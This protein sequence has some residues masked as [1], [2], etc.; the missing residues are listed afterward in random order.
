[1]IFIFQMKQQI[2]ILG[3]DDAPFNFD[4]KYTTIIGVVMRGGEYLECVLRSHVTIDGTEAT[5]N[6]KEMIQN[7][8]HRRQ[9]KVIMLDGACLG[10]FNVVDID[11]LSESINLPVLTITRDKPDQQKIKHALQKNF[12]DWKDRWSLLQKGKLHKIATQHNPIYIKCT[13]LLL[14]EAKEIINISTIR[15][16]IPEPIRVAHL[17][18]SGITRG[19]SYGKA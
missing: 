1:M 7:S 15:G 13:G 10:G 11:E 9:L 8:R 17:I 18:A 12:M 19:E 2:R 3:I 4:E 14:E 16:V 6:C 5:M